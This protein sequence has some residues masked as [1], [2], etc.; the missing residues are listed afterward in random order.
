MGF[1]GTWLLKKALL[2]TLAASKS[3]AQSPRSGPQYGNAE[4]E[5]QTQVTVVD[6]YTDFIL[7]R[8]SYFKSV[9]RR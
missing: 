1:T 6:K 9:V 7:K 3:A 2:H 5:I 4:H 8:E